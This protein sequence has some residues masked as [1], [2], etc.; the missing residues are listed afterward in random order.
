MMEESQDIRPDFATAA[1]MCLDGRYVDAFEAC[2]KAFGGEPDSPALLDLGLQTL[3]LRIMVAA[4]EAHVEALAGRW[5]AG[6]RFGNPDIA[7][8]ILTDAF[9]DDPQ[10]YDFFGNFAALSVRLGRGD[11]AV[12]LFSHCLGPELPARIE[13]HAIEEKYRDGLDTYDEVFLHDMAVDRFLAFLSPRL[14]PDG[15]L[16]IVDACCGTGLAAP[17]LRPLARTLAGIDLSASMLER[18]RRR[19]LYDSL[20]VGDVV[21]ELEGRVADLVVCCGAANYFRDLA[22][23]GRAVFQCL[24]PG[25]LFAFSDFPAPDGVMITTGGS[26]RYCRGRR[27]VRDM[28][29]RIG[30]EEVGCDLGVMYGLPCYLWMFR[31]PGAAP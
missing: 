3:V 24:R 31:R 12:R 5:I 22:P 9:R 29:S 2:I 16:D 15:N 7:E 28:M 20:T 30:M 14:E 19:D 26:L 1:G 8:V 17:H 13:R 23:L 4:P 25:G 21:A 11:S 18:A 27:T 10:A 6:C